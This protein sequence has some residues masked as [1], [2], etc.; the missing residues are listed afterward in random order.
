VFVLVFVE[1]VT[2]E[3]KKSLKSLKDELRMLREKLSL[4]LKREI[5]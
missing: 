4:K 1:F 2:A 3:I 5:K